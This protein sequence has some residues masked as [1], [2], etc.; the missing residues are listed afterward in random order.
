[1][2]NAYAAWMT[3]GTYGNFNDAL[4]MALRKKKAGAVAVQIQDANKA[5]VYSA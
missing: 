4:S 3:A 1:M 5:V 2:S